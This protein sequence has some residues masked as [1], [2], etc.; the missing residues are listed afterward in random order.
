M[1]YSRTFS[2]VSEQKMQ[3]DSVRQ[4]GQRFCRDHVT[5]KGLP[6]GLNKACAGRRTTNHSALFPV[7]RGPP[8]PEWLLTCQPH[9][10]TVTVHWPRVVN[11]NQNRRPETPA[12]VLS[13]PTPTRRPLCNPD[14]ER[15]FRNGPA[16][17]LLS[18]SLLCY[19]YF[20]LLSH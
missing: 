13:G 7:L 14:P 5:D 19:L 17:P 2:L 18:L 15:S 3:E 10:V 4:S 9:M 20:P 1:P 12:L 8:H 11:K 6:R 16:I